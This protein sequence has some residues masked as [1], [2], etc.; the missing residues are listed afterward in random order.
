[1]NLNFN[2]FFTR[3]GFFHFA[4]F[5]PSVTSAQIELAGFERLGILFQPTCF[6][7]A[8]HPILLLS[9]DPIL[10]DYIYLSQSVPGQ[11]PP[12]PPSP[13]TW[14]VT[15]LRD[16]SYLE[17]ID[18]SIILPDNTGTLF[19]QT[20]QNPCELIAGVRP[21]KEF[22]L[23]LELSGVALG[24]IYVSFPE[25]APLLPPPPMSLLPP[26]PQLLPPPPSQLPPALTDPTFP[27]GF[28]YPPGFLWPSQVHTF[29]PWFYLMY[30]DS[31][32]PPLGEL[33]YI[34]VQ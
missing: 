21:P 17:P 22:G 13:A 12:L 8:K 10:R 16:P 30:G 1:M 27:P 4:Y 7:A 2:T 11:L 29:Y 24:S 3:Y 18:L 26:P 32:L 20:T 23:S 31:K 15:N 34:P 6:D 14:S 9:L 33:P 5:D 28:E 19:Y 25:P